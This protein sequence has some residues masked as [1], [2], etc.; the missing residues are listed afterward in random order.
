MVDA[1][2]YRLHKTDM[3]Q[4]ETQPATDNERARVGLTPA[5]HNCLLFIAGYLKATG[6]VSPSFEEIRVALGMASK[7]G[8]HRLVSQLE[9]RGYL[10]RLPGSSRSLMLLD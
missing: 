6:G 2:K 10:R 4:T 7:S 8:P 1:Y 9:K 3:T 5:Q